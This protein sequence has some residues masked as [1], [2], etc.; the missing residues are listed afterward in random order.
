MLAVRPRSLSAA[1]LLAA[2]AACS[3][4]E[5]EPA[6]SAAPPASAARAAVP[7]VEG[8]WLRP[9]VAG[10]S[11]GGGF[12]TMTSA[13]GDRLVGG[14][15]PVAEKLELHSMS[16]DDG[17]MRMR[18]VPAIDLPA[19]Q[20]VQLGPGG[21]HLMLIGPR[22]PLNAG[23]TVPLTLRFEKAGEVTVQAKVSAAAP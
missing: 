21:L 23:D 19:G 5:A 16:M 2:L 20:P 9:I 7:H 17:V 6:S 15:T 1:L 22:Q 3:K 10:Q 14:S 11:G 12:L 8:A 18:E 13:G 4:Q